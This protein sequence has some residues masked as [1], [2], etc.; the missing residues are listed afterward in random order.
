MNRNFVEN[1]SRKRKNKKWKDCF[2]DFASF[3]KTKEKAKK[4]RKTSNK[5]NIGSEIGFN[6]DN[7]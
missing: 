4:K 3:S 1:S 7:Y 5:R 2:R 6:D